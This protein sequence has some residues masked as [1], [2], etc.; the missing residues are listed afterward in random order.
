MVV[1]SF[2]GSG[3]VVAAIPGD[4]DLMRSVAAKLVA[5]GRDAILSVADDSGT[6]VV[7]MRAP[8]ST[9]DC[10]ALWKQLAGKFGGRGGG[11][12]DRAEGKLPVPIADWA[13]SVSTLT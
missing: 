9:L 4:A 12:A 5:A 13:Q 7:L 8:G 10:G 3:P 1:E 2:T 6:A 11:K